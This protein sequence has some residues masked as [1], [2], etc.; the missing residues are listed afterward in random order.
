VHNRKTPLG[1]ARRFG[2]GRGFSMVEMM[3]ALVVLS[4]GML[5]VASLF[6][7][8]LSS[9][10]SAISRMQAVSL[11]NDLADRIRSNP[12]AQGAYKAAGAGTNHNC[13]GGAVGA[14]K[15]VP[16]DMAA[17]DMFVWN[18]QIASA[19]PGGS[20]TG[21]VDAVNVAGTGLW[22]YTITVSWKEAGAAAATP[23]SYKLMMQQ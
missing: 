1:L 22:T 11:A 12:T 17:N 21:S 2:A 9:G 20:G 13:V 15:C 7:T 23:Q 10:S 16:A 18:A 5:G 4:V 6:A 3:V 19:W 14:V 8:S